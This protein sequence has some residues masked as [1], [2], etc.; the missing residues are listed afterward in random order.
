M[1][2]KPKYRDEYILCAA[3]WFDDGKQYIAQP[4]NISSGIVLS[5]WRHSAIFPQIGGLVK[6]RTELGIYEKEQ[7][8][9]TSNN[10]FV[11]RKETAKIAFNANQILKEKKEL[12]S[13]DLY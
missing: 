7:G 6:E 13:E 1:E 10:R 4:N 5:G 9:L 8:F 3:T 2:A 12:Y 11:D